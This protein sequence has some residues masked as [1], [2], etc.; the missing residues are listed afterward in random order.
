MNVEHFAKMRALEAAYVSTNPMF[1]EAV[2]EGRA[3]VEPP[4]KLKRLQFDCTPE[5]Y[6]RVEQ[7]CNL[8][9]CSKRQFMEAAIAEALDRASEA[10][11]GTYKEVAGQEF[12][13][14]VEA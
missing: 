9:D 11:F 2:F 6:E 3:Q 5:F 14:P 12:G 8:L 7:M 13:E 4:L 1:T 10:F